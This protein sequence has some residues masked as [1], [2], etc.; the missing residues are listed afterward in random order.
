MMPE[1]LDPS[2]ELQQLAS[3]ALQYSTAAASQHQQQQDEDE[4][5]DDLHQHHQF[6]IPTSLPTLQFT[7]VP[8]L[9]EQQSSSRGSA[10]PEAKFA[11]PFPT[12]NRRYKR[13]DLLKRHLTTLLASPDEHHHD[14]AVWDHIRENGMMTIYT[15][16]RNLTEDQKKQRRKES[17]LRHRVKYATELKEKRNRKR[18]VE[19]LLEGRQVGVQTPDWEEEARIAAAAAAVVAESALNPELTAMEHVPVGVDISAMDPSF[20]ATATSSATALPTM[21]D[22]R[23]K[24]GRKGGRKQ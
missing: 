17:N 23:P 20:S 19:K 22:G 15:R 11:C 16:P 7:D 6:G 3:Q 12:C 4:D 14:N 8:T 5:D 9:E 24:T 2:L 18:R 10:D 13:K 1:G 21:A